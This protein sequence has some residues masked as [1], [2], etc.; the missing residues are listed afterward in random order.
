MRGDAGMQFGLE[1]ARAIVAVERMDRPVD[2]DDFKG[3]AMALGFGEQFVH[4]LRARIP[5]LQGDYAAA[6]DVVVETLDELPEGETVTA[7]FFV[8]AAIAAGDLALA[9]RVLARSYPE[10]TPRQRGMLTKLARGL[11]L[12]AEGNLAD[13]RPLF[14][15]SAAWFRGRTRNL[16]AREALFALGRS[17]VGQ[18]EIEAGL[19]NLREAR[20]IAE[21]LRTPLSIAEIDAAIDAAHVEMLA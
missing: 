15:E 4:G 6:R 7:V 21:T 12:E 14:E 19:A 3:Q 17:Q 10:S 16:P 9:R 20:A 11:V 8:T 13:A 1:W 2:L 18:G 5:Y